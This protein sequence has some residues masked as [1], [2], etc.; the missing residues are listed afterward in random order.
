MSNRNL[1]LREFDTNTL[2][3][4]SVIVTR[5]KHGATTLLK[6]L[7]R[8]EMAKDSKLRVI[9]F[10]P[11]MNLP[12]P[13][14]RDIVGPTYMHSEFTVELLEGILDAQTHFI[15]HYNKGEVPTLLLAVDGFDLNNTGMKSD[16]FRR[17]VFNGRFMKIRLILTMQYL[18]DIPVAI[19]SNVD[20]W[21]IAGTPYH[22]DQK[23][24]YE[25]CCSQVLNFKSFKR[26]LEHATRGNS[27]L[28]SDNTAS[29]NQL[30]DTL[31]WYRAQYTNEHDA[32]VVLIKEK[33]GACEQ[34]HE[35][36]E[37]DPRAQYTNE[38]DAPVVLIKEKEEACEQ[39]HEVDEFDPRAQYNEQDAPVVLIKEK[40]EACEQGHEA[41][42]FDPRAQ[43]NE[44]DAPVVLI[45][46]KEEA[47]EQ[48]HEV[49]EFDPSKLGSTTVIIGKRGAGATTLLKDLCRHE[50]VRDS[51]IRII[52]FDPTMNFNPSGLSCIVDSRLMHT[53]ITPEMI[54]DIMNFQAQLVR[55]KQHE[56]PTLL[57]ALDGIESN[58]KFMK[59]N[60]F[61]RLLMNSHHI[62]IRTI[63]TMHCMSDMH[64]SVR[65]NV[66]TWFLARE[67]HDHSFLVSQNIC[68]KYGTDDTSISWY[69]SQLDPPSPSC[70][71]VLVEAVTPTAEKAKT[72]EKTVEKKTVQT[73]TKMQANDY[74][75]TLAFLRK[76]FTT[77]QRFR[78]FMLD[79]DAAGV[80]A[81]AKTAVHVKE[82]ETFDVALTMLWDELNNVETD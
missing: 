43:Y 1:N 13:G 48:G 32:P 39:G 44:Q 54:E 61:E 8:H 25:N 3:S 50:L 64:V 63:L 20:A 4:F 35:V 72:V 49:D 5:H 45:K 15:R 77:N 40:E 71:H 79:A 58:R 31:F 59:S 28:V 76:M 55:H 67:T 62:K 81:F 33:E 23:R 22:T 26:I 16:A 34:G 82:I 37:F 46:K 2:G 42:E 11:S 24:L 69:K 36:D 66:E 29:S 21:F 65:T 78:S 17:L 74:S 70:A 47:C 68:P 10:D 80:H 7:C 53:T 27:F 38:H 56:A 51:E 14:L 73:K 57:L 19:R 30:E 52:G 12:R 41:D 75:H 9:G 6:D 60:T 18:F